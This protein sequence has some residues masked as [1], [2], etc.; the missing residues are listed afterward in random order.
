MLQPEKTIA[1]CDDCWAELPLLVPLSKRLAE[2]LRWA[3]SGCSAGM[4][5]SIAK[6]EDPAQPV[7]LGE[8]IGGCKNCLL[9]LT[10]PYVHFHGGLF[11]HFQGS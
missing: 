6:Q 3:G 9:H 10:K 2:I 11:R 5:Y 1:V 4:M 7:L 8:V